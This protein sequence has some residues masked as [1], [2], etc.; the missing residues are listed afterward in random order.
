MGRDD[1]DDRTKSRIILMDFRDEDTMF[2]VDTKARR[3]L[4]PTTSM[5]GMFELVVYFS[6]SF[7]ENFN[8]E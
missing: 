5:S 3:G 4:L 1:D 7:Q 6:A 2:G 8:K